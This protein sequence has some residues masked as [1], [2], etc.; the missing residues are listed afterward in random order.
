MQAAA[1]AQAHRADTKLVEIRGSF[2]QEQLT[3]MAKIQRLENE[4]RSAKLDT[5]LAEETSK[6]GGQ[7]DLQDTEPFM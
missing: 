3:V 1:K 5:K 7:Q 2:R 6:K 4:L